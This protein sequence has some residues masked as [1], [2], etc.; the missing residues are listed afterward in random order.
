MGPCENTST[1]ID[2]INNN[3]PVLNE[4]FVGEADNNMN[5]QSVMHINQALQRVHNQ[6]LQ[7]ATVADSIT[8]VLAKA[9][10]MPVIEFFVNSHLILPIN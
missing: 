4:D 8:Q 3:I 6:E 2:V 9:I 10:P 1:L 7:R 5:S